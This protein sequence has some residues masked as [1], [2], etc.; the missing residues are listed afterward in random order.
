[1]PLVAFGRFWTAALALALSCAIAVGPPP[2]V[3]FGFT[4]ER[5][6][7]ISWCIVAMSAGDSEYN[8]PDVDA[9]ALL[10]DPRAAL[11]TRLIKQLPVREQ[12]ELPPD[13]WMVDAGSVP[14]RTRWVVSPGISIEVQVVDG[15]GNTIAFVNLRGDEEM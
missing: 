14:L 12:S 2:R 4:A 11:G 1:M 3:R 6:E 8:T 9:A 15:H 10:A 13:G 7:T 5:P